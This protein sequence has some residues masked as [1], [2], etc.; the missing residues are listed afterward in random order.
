[1]ACTE[2]AEVLPSPTITIPIFDSLIIIFRNLAIMGQVRQ[3]WEE[4][5][6]IKLNGNQNLSLY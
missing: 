5:K 2:L 3:Q 6:N 1:M 4:I